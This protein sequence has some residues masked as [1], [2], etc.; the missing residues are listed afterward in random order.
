M[1]VCV[2]LHLVHVL[3]V[4]ILPSLKG[5]LIGRVRG[6]RLIQVGQV[7]S[8]HGCCEV[9]CVLCVYHSNVSTDLSCRLDVPLWCSLPCPAVD[10]ALEPWLTPLESGL[11]STLRV[12]TVVPLPTL[13]SSMASLVLPA[14]CSLFTLPRVIPV[15]FIRHDNSGITRTFKIML[16]TTGHV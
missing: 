8:V 2:L 14:F 10:V 12:G 1:E 13:A 11:L 5:Y 15:T 6:W 3:L 9:R 7:Q 16:R 4:H